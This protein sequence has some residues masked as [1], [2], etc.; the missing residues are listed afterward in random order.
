M[1]AI[2]AFLGA[3][4]MIKIRADSKEVTLFGNIFYFVVYLLYYAYFC[5]FILVSI[6]AIL[7]NLFLNKIVPSILLLIVN[8]VY[9]TNF[10]I[11]FFNIN[12]CTVNSVKFVDVSTAIIYFPHKML[13][14][15]QRMMS[16]TV[17]FGIYI[18]SVIYCS[19]NKY[20]N[21]N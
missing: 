16:L 12:L 20:L 10:N 18:F 4:Y 21:T 8:Y 11:I 7:L 13:E 15:K 9:C 2:A 19:M 3:C 14:C 6:Y 1:I 5:T 17:K